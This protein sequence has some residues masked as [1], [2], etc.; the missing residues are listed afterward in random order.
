MVKELA[1][2]KLAITYVDVGPAAVIF[3]A[4]MTKQNFPFN[5]KN[6]MIVLEKE[7]R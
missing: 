7:V 2:P 5:P 6:P 4:A 1:P 3:E